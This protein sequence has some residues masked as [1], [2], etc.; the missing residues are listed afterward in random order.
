M[1][2]AGL[3]RLGLGHRI[4]ER[5]A[6]E[7]M[8][9]A[10]G[11]GAIAAQT[12]VEDDRALEAAR[13]IDDAATRAAVVAERGFLNAMGGGCQRPISAW[14][15]V[16][17]S[18]LIIDGAVSDAAGRRI[19]RAQIVTTAADPTRAGQSL[20][21]RIRRLGADALLAEAVS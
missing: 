3:L 9:P 8:L 7:V 13:A 17:G 16:E 2:A 19:I 1:A 21:E 6:P 18:R 5:F 10:V 20:A 14:A 15:R 4:S 11:Q 12:R